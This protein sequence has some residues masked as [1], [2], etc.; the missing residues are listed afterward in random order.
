[1]S[2]L[3]AAVVVVVVNFQAKQLANKLQKAGEEG[4]AAAGARCGVLVFYLMF[5]LERMM[6]D[7]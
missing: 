5:H 4:D 1:M 6:H 2:S 7:T 3:Q